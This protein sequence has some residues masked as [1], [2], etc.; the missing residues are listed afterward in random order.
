MVLV[1]FLMYQ[2]NKSKFIPKLCSK[3]GI[4]NASVMIAIMP[5]FSALTY[6]CA[7]SLSFQPKRIFE[8]SNGGIGRALNTAKMMLNI[9]K[10]MKNIVQKSWMF[11]DGIN[12]Q[13]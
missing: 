1:M 12:E 13:R 10:L 4:T 8:P 5:S 7:H 11:G 9:I 3:R 6:F 2:P